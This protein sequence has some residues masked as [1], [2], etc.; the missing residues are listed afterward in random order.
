ME[1]RNKEK[2]LSGK[3]SSMLGLTTT[4]NNKPCLTCSKQL[5]D[6]GMWNNI[7]GQEGTCDAS[8][9]YTILISDWVSC[10]MPITA[11][12][13]RAIFRLNSY[14]HDEDKIW[15]MANAKVE[16]ASPSEILEIK[17]NPPEPTDIVLVLNPDAFI[18]LENSP[19]EF[20]EHYQ[21]LA[22]I[23]EKQEQYLEEINTQLC[24]HCL[25]SCDFQFC[26]DCDL[27][28]NSPPRM[29]YTIPEE[30]EPINSCASELE[31][32]SNPDSNFDNNNNKNNSFSSI[33]NS[34]NNNNNSN[35]NSNSDSNYE[36]YIILSD[37]IKKQELK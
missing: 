19:E 21:N 23:R 14:P 7:P 2:N 35:S 27:I 13:H 9:Q 37:L 29:I 1:R 31:S 5:L 24:N 8:C 12:W 15:R 33:Q 3:P 22:P 32:S 6:E 30:E 4:K 18:D 26:D 34:Y 16:G 11:A 28:Y 17:N 25:I 10:G 20:H 36:Q